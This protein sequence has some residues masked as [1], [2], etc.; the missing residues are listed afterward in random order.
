MSLRLDELGHASVGMSGTLHDLVLPGS[1][2]GVAPVTRETALVLRLDA[3][4]PHGDAFRY[5]ITWYGLEP[6]SYALADY[7][8]RVDG[9]SLAGLPAHTLRVTSLLAPGRVEPHPPAVGDLPRLGGYQTL[10]ILGGI[11]WCVG[12]VWILTRFRR[13]AAEERAPV[14][15]GVSLAERLRPL[16]AAAR[17]QELSP[18]GRAEL[19]LAL[20]AF[21][22]K[23]LGLAE[24][25]PVLALRELRAH[26]DAG[27]LLQGLEDWLH[28]PDPPA[29][30]LERLLAPYADLPADALELPAALEGAAR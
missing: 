17:A 6:G 26:P 28:R 21:W 19:E 13:K 30:D 8:V 4:R 12:L 15:R 25:D 11:L 7:L 18:A 16:V 3:V 24:R 9:T 5:D 20:L 27:P 2:L 14:A 1:E 22:R 10:L 23:R 29:V